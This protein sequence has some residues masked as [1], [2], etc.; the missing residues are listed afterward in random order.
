MLGMSTG[1]IGSTS[2]AVAAP[3]PRTGGGCSTRV[4]GSG[5]GH[6]P[7]STLI[8]VHD[9]APD[10]GSIIVDGS[11][12]GQVGRRSSADD[13]V[14]RTGEVTPRPLVRGNVRKSAFI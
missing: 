13:P 3:E 11:G 1:W 2:A 9:R 12:A 8:G 10:G 4:D 14:S 7:W 5:A 6:G